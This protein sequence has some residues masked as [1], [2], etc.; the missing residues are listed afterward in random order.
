MHEDRNEP[1][2]PEEEVAIW[3]LRTPYDGELEGDVMGEGSAKYWI[4]C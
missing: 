1:R 3:V 2:V 4:Q